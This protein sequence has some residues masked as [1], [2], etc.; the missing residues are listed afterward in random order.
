MVFTNVQGV[1]WNILVSCH[2]TRFYVPLIK[3][4]AID[5]AVQNLQLTFQNNL[6]GSEDDY[7]KSP[8]V[9]NTT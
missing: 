4:P 2:A 7:Y 1:E 8:Y 6:N 3:I 5:A 9:N